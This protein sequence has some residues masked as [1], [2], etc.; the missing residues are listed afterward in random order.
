M[1]GL[2]KVITRLLL[3]AIIVVP[4]LV[5]GPVRLPNELFT[6]RARTLRIE[7]RR[8]ELL[9][10][11]PS[12]TA[13]SQQ[14]LR[15]SEMGDVLPQVTVALEDHR[16]YDHKGVDFYAICA[17]ANRNFQHPAI[18][19]GASTITQQ[20]IKLASG[21]RGRRVSSKIY[22]AVAAIKLERRWSKQR[23]LE[24]YLNRTNYGNRFIGPAAAAKAYFGKKVPELSIN[25]AIFL[26]GLP[27]AP[28]RFNPWT[29]YEA[30]RAKYERSIDRLAALNWLSFDQA[31]HLRKNCPAVQRNFPPKRAPHFV[32]AVSALYPE[33]LGALRTSL[34]LK[35][36][37]SIERIVESRL[38]ELSA[39]GVSDVAV[40]VM[41]N[42][43]GGIRAMV[44]SGDYARSQ[45]NGAM[46]PRSCGSTLKPFVYLYGIDR[47]E[48]TAA[49]LMPDTQDAARNEFF[50]Y[51]PQN[52]THR[53]FGPVR[54]RDAL[55]S[56]LNVPAV[57]AVSRLGAREVFYE[58]QKWGF[59]FHRTLGEY[60]AG[61]VLGNAEIRLI[62]LAAAYAGLARGGISTRPA[63]LEQ[64]R[65][66]GSRI[67]SREG[68]AIV[69][70]ILCDND[71]RRYSFS[72]ISPLKTNVRIGVKTGTSSGFRDALT[73][74]YDKD[75]TVAVWAGNLNG[76]PMQELPA[77]RAAAP[78]WRQV[79]DHMVANGD[80]ELPPIVESDKLHAVTIC[81]ITG[82]LPAPE[83]SKQTHKEWFLA[84]TEPKVSASSNLV[85]IDGKL[86][87]TLPA[88]YTA[89]CRSPENYLGAIV[90][91]ALSLKITQPR[92]RAVFQID[93]LLAQ[94]QQM[95]E[96]VATTPSKNVQWF[97]DGKEIA[98][99]ANGR[100]FWQLEPG[101]R[102]AVIVVNGERASSKF[103]VK[104]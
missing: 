18:L 94:R 71:A 86:K 82:D 21:R 20:T 96:L 46:V 80:R 31:E 104:N 38:D 3:A 90:S 69:A 44:G 65:F 39:R 6:P 1:R 8:G 5:Y 76:R 30:A 91:P 51:D 98:P 24:E 102:E 78:L 14:P 49:T 28:S 9:A 4:L 45:L 12:D 79:M 47:R 61:F 64:E 25:E 73:V 81:S 29:Q 23:I 40:V 99:D 63:F 27:Q 7:D 68:V 17:A 58:L 93:S 11:I 92:D 50:D 70:D 35:L 26:A 56:S 33:R 55:G 95:L 48:L 85:E 57:V 97:I 84:G 37:N 41:D 19:S 53:H 13:R 2:R 10:E 101:E 62:D 87:L 83:F 34:D 103:A 66:A 52:Y 15:L 16:F 42:A 77:V 72:R 75:H 89:W 54:L 32:D 43:T 88:E 22:E 59:K 67:A 100:Y 74:G 60:G 36:Q